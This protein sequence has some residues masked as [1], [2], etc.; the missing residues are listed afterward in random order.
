MRAMVA[1]PELPVLLLLTVSAAA[2]AGCSRSTRLEVAPE[3]SVAPGTYTADVPAAKIRDPGL[4]ENAGSW[5]LTFSEADSLSVFRG[6]EPLGTGR[7]RVS[8]NTIT[9]RDNTPACAR[10]GEGVYTWRRSGGEVVFTPRRDPCAAR[11]A[12]LSAGRWGRAG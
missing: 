10:T 2:G 4:K 3:A 1:P 12:V 8:G 9:L 7:Y 6:T 5:T 11:R